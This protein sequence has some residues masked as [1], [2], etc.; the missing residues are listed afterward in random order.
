MFGVQSSTFFAG[1]IFGLGVIYRSFFVCTIL[2]F[3]CLIARQSIRH[4]TSNF[5]VTRFCCQK[6]LLNTCISC[7]LAQSIS[8]CKLGEGG[9]RVV[10]ISDVLLE[11]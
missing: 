7:E 9:S 8:P 5:D 1:K 11:G 10:V 3:C 2:I 6:C 4:L